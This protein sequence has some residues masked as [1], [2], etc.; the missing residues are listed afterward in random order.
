[1]IYVFPPPRHLLSTIMQSWDNT[2]IQ[3]PW[4]RGNSAMVL[5]WEK[6]IQLF[7]GGRKG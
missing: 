1:M 7:L 4:V 2:G 5:S 3:D 6:E